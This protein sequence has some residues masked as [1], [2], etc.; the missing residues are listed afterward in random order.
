MY[1]VCLEPFA[2]IL[3]QFGH[4]TAGRIETDGSHIGNF[5]ITFYWGSGFTALQQT[6][7]QLLKK[8]PAFYYVRRIIIVFT[9]VHHWVSP[10]S[11]LHPVVLL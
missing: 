4:L 8:F 1:H 2:L 7:T 3:V 5:G 9:R 10:L 6:V 11:Q